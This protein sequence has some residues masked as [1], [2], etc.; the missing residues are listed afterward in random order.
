[1]W[2]E[3]LVL[4]AQVLE[5][6][7]PGMTIFLGTGIAEPRTLVKHLMASNNANLQDLELIQLVSLGDAVAIDERYTRKFRLKTF[8]SGWIADDAIREGRVDLIPSRFSR[9]PG[10]LEPGRSISMWRSFRLHLPTSR[11]M[12]IL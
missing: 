6:I 4:P 3:K 11:D 5:K 1:M 8:F 7:T 10:Y 12:P 9:I 2:Q